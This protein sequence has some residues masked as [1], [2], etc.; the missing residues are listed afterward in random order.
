MDENTRENRCKITYLVWLL[1][2]ISTPCVHGLAAELHVV[3]HALKLLREGKTA[4]DLQLC[5]HAAFRIVADAAPM[6][7]P[8]REMAFVVP[9]EHVL[10]GDIS[11][12][13]DGLFE[14]ELD[15]SVRFLRT[16]E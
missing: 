11:E 2:Q 6:Q 8:L 15:L 14:D 7:Q 5:E 12:D 9:L 16:T 10:V 4:L 1:I 3:E 13:G